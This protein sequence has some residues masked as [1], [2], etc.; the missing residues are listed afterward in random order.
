MVDIVVRVSNLRKL[1]GRVEALRDISFM[2]FRGEIFGVVGPNGAGK[3]TLL[4]IIAGLMKPSSGEVEVLGRRVPNDV[5]EIRKYI[6]YLPEEA[7]LYSKLSGVENLR[8]F[9]MAYVGHE[10]IDEVVKVGFSI[11]GLNPR[12]L[13]RRAETYSKGMIRRVAVAST[14]M[15]KPQLAILDE[16][17]AGLDVVSARYVRDVI[18]HYAREFGTSVIFSSHNMF[19]VSRVCDRIALIHSGRVIAIDSVSEILSK[20]GAEDLEEAFVKLTGGRSE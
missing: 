1:F 15:V 8:L 10:S 17:T 7:N 3:T 5:S 18:K 20:V 19:E 9:A 6:S 13:E 16:P 12:D 2:V 14:L 4:R 11:A